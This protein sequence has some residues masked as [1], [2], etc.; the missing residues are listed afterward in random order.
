MPVGFTE[1]HIHPPVLTR[2][3]RLFLFLFPQLVRQWGVHTS[4]ERE[5]LIFTAFNKQ[6]TGGLHARLPG[7]ASEDIP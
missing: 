5:L 4:L 1:V 3:W 7:P 2:Y 6:S